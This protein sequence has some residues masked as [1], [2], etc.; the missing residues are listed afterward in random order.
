MIA[1][2]EENEDQLLPDRLVRA[3]EAGDTAGG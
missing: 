1:T 2:F 3:I